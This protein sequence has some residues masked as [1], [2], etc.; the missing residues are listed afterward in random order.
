MSHNTHIL[1]FGFILF[2]FILVCLKIKLIKKTRRK[3]NF[4]IFTILSY[5]AHNCL[6]EAQI[7][8][9]RMCSITTAALM[10]ILI[11]SGHEERTIDS[12]TPTI[13]NQRLLF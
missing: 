5:N 13:M 9:T 8:V 6:A 11:L 2:S 1:Q 3:F 7:C 4:K 12:S 10:F